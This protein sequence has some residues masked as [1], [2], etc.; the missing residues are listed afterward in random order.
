M[1][2]KLDI[3]ETITIILLI[4][5]VLNFLLFIRVQRDINE[6]N[7]RQQQINE[8]VINGVEN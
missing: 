2:E 7:K 6:F 4:V 5:N 1:E 3:Y 8:Y